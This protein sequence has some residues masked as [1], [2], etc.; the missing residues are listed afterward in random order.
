MQ[1]QHIYFGVLYLF[2]RT[3]L[4]STQCIHSDYFILFWCFLW[5]IYTDAT[6]SFT[7][8]RSSCTFLELYFCMHY[9]H[10]LRIILTRQTLQYAT[11]SVHKPKYYSKRLEIKILCI[12]PNNF[13][14][15]NYSRIYKDE[16]TYKSL[17]R[18]IWVCAMK[19][20]FS[21]I[22]TTLFAQ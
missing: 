2:F 8:K 16:V 1:K 9:E 4:G 17:N 15:T 12:I 5:S 11:A 10:E 13:M 6:H 19:S 7:S 20:C 3:T 14:Y 22:Y 21:F 18:N